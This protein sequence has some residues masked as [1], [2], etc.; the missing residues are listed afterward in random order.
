LF[1]NYRQNTL[2]FEFTACEK[3]D[4]G[5]FT[6]F[7]LPPMA[8]L[9]L[10]IKERFPYISDEM[11]TEILSMGKLVS[12]SAGEIFIKEGEMAGHAAMIIQGMLRNYI[13]ND[14]G[15]EVTV[16]FGSDM[17]VI[18]PYATV[19]LNKPATETTIAVEDSLL[20][21][22]EL[23]PYKE[24]V[25][26]DLLF[27]RLYT[28][29]LEEAFIAA[30]ERIEDLTKKKPEQ[31]YLRLLATHGELIERAPLKYLA[32]YLGITPVSL[33]RIRKRLSRPKS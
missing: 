18:T 7:N 19:F 11:L 22:F 23:K 8:D 2:S 24:K 14:K 21:V 29:I 10:K 17:Q 30:I 15:E 16:V 5:K 25:K 31:R 28:E 3:I 13:L 1:V 33:S 6:I 9:L 12:L 27:M 20:F 4:F 26:D 32:S